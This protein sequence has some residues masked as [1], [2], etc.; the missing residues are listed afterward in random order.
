[1]NEHDP[2]TIDEIGDFFAELRMMA[3][4]LLANRGD[5][6]SIRPTALVI[7]ALRRNKRS[8]QSWEDI[9]WKNRKYMF[10]ALHKAMRRSL[11][12]HYKKTQ[13]KR[14][15]TLEFKPHD[16]LSI[17]AEDLDLTNFQETVL[18]HPERIYAVTEALTWLEKYYPEHATVVQHRFIS[19][20]TVAETADMMGVTYDVVQSYWRKAKPLLAQQILRIADSNQGD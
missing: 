6:H 10:G 15:P 19:G 8:N 1:M 3:R 17:S 7:S 16:E 18:N 14:R 9:T 20:L 2:I 11:I 4:R 12:D 13:A 5:A